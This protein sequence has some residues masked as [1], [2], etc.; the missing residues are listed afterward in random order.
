MRFRLQIVL[1]FILLFLFFTAISYSFTFS[2]YEKQENDSR[3]NATSDRQLLSTLSCP[4]SLAGK[5]IATMIGEQ[6]RDDYRGYLGTV[7]TIG[8][9]DWDRR[10]G[11]KN[12]VYG[13][14]M[15]Q[16]NQ[17]FTELGLKTYTNAEIN[18]QIARA[19]QEAFL[20]NDTEGAL[21]AAKRLRAD[22]LVKGII[23]TRT[24]TNKVIKIEEVF[25]TIS[26]T[27]YDKNGTQLSTAQV[28][29]AVFSDTDT[30]GT[31][32]SLVKEQSYA[33]VYQLFKDYCLEEN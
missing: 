23:S 9:P 20:N 30:L 19:E 1:P 2:E 6:H 17:G 31:V 4:T 14:L 26:L 32:Q 12:Q 24:Q 5:K 8:E 21:T 28:K 29:K 10:F 11:T 25:V 15:A 18:N 27:L 13:P 7:I 33:I 22:F 16:L 3:K